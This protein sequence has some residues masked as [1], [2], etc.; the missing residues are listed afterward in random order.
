MKMKPINQIICI[1]SL[2]LLSADGTP[3]LAQTT[4]NDDVLING[5]N[6]TANFKVTGNNGSVF[7]GTLGS[8]SIPAT[9]AGTRM[10][11]YPK[12]AA[13]RMGRVTNHIWDDADTG[14]YS[15]GGGL[16]AEAT[17]QYS[18]AYGAGAAAGGVASFAGG[19]CIALGDY[20]V[21]FGSSNAIG[22]HS[23]ATGLA[24]A[25]G[26]Y[27]TATGMGECGAD[28][29]TATGGGWVNGFAG[30]AS[31]FNTMSNSLGETVFGLWN[32]YWAG[33]ADTWVANDSLL[34]IGNGVDSENLSNALV[35]QKD[36]D[37]R[38]NGKGEYKGGLRA[39]PLGD[40]SM[41]SFTSGSNPS[42]LDEALKYSGE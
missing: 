35:L 29:G 39:A 5:D 30:T 34:M 19:N 2:Y 33:S 4:T 42:S 32:A 40:L 9:G 20:S 18:F 21:A 3:L 15:F 17:G 27:S 7:T 13:F 26:D 31:G 11:W 8:G 36:G 16:D 23:L 24:Y 22:V 10:M 14:E 25:W 6:G 37:L 38:A 1:L 41:G 28:F 12:K